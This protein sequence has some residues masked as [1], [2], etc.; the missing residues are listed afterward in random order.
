M[1]N[2]NNINNVQNIQKPISMVL[3]ELRENLTVQ[4]NSANLPLCLVEPI[5][6]DLYM[7]V[8]NLSE[9]QTRKDIEEYNKAIENEEST[10]A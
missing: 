4:I 8:H 9:V 10:T 2:I 5:V 6:K 1:D 3:N 7:E